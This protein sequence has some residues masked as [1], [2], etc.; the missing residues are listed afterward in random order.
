M[1]ED[2]LSFI[3]KHR[4]FKDFVCF[5]IEGQS[6]EIKSVGKQ[7]KN[8]G[9]DFIEAKIK[10]DGTTWV[11]NVELHS[12]SSDW[13]LHKHYQDKAYNN[14]ILQVVEKHDKDV[15]TEDGRVLPVIELKVSESLR[16]KYAEFLQASNWISCEKDTKVVDSIKLKM[17][18]GN[19][20]IERLNKKA[21]QIAA[22]L[23]ANKNNWEETFYQLVARSFGFKVNA[24]PFEWMAKS[25]PLNILAKH[26]NNL[27]QLEALLFGQAGFLTER[28]DD[29]YFKKLK[30]EY[31]FLKQK[32]NLIPS[33]K[34]LWKFLRL[35]PSNF[36][37][38][39]LAQF[40]MLIYKSKSLFSKVIEIDEIEEM[41]NLFDISASAFWEEH[42]TFEKTSTTKPK[43]LGETSINSILIN[44]VIPMLFV[45]G[46]HTDDENLKDKAISF[47]EM[48]APE[49]NNIIKSWKRLGIDV[50]SSFYSQALLEQKS[51]Y[52]EKVKCLKCGIGIEI[53]KNQLA[54]N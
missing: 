33:E 16:L 47:L 46:K 30:N 43:T 41:K 49:K 39:R 9:P 23:Q 34:H 45:Y 12:K 18:L 20:L 36:P 42:Y 1:S 52:C 3:W 54:K 44:A 17:W 6:P 19:V 15:F 10:V 8:A 40:A 7:N 21:D 32:F 38:I 27:F 50:S 4:L 2:L 24:E 37:H 5:N 22:M 48:L 51:S 28:I 35:R 53:F 25:L 11:G 14:V 31:I 26:Q 29:E 13:N